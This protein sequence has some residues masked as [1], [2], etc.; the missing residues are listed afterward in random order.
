M[1][2]DEHL[3][4]LYAVR[5]S[6]SAALAGLNLYMRRLGIEQPDDADE[7]TDLG[8]VAAVLGDAVR[9]L[10]PPPPTDARP[11][12]PLSMAEMRR[13]LDTYGG[14]EAGQG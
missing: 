5:A 6:L 1:T 2:G 12:F 9:A 14:G 10:R 13:L 11:A 4:M 3:P 7:P 8:A